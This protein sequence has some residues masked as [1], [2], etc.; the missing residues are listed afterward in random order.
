MEIIKPK[1]TDYPGEHIRLK[2]DTP[3]LGFEEAREM[4]QQKAREMCADPMPLSWYQG[5]T[6]ESYPNIE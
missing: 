2:A 1:V 5:E 4:A 3:D 6:G